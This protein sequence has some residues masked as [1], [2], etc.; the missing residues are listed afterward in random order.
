MEQSR[1]FIYRI[2]NGRLARLTGAGAPWAIGT[3]QSSSI[4]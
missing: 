4:A 2:N 3:G 1:E